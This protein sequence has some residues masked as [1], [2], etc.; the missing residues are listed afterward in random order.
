MDRIWHEVAQAG[1]VFWGT[2][3]RQATSEVT[4]SAIASTEGV[5]SAFQN[6]AVGMGVNR[7]AILA[8]QPF[9][10]SAATETCIFHWGLDDHWVSKYRAI[11]AMRIDR[12]PDA[13]IDRARPILWRDMVKWSAISNENMEVLNEF[14]SAHGRDGISIPLY[15]P[16]G[17]QALI[18]LSFDT[19]IESI[20]EPRVVELTRV[21]MLAHRQY[22]MLK[23]KKLVPSLALSDRERQV[24]AQIAGGCSKKQVARNLGLSASSVDTYQ[25]RIFFK[26]EVEDRT[27]A[28]IKAL[29][30]GL[31]KL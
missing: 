3:M 26:L 28:A 9:H 21:A 16:Y 19:P 14:F 31:I 15:G 27:S 13:I 20:D 25:R 22:V 23:R 1:L 30:M 18:S 29:S 6:V 24:L 12:I 7:C 4:F 17:H 8:P 10:F 11:L 5:I 2:T